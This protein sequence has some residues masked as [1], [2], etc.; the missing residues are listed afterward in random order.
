MGLHAHAHTREPLASAG[1]WRYVDEVACARGWMW[2]G[3]VLTSGC[4]EPTESPPP[5]ISSG[6][7]TSA[8]TGDDS[9]TL[10]DASATSGVADPC[11]PGSPPDGDT[12][13]E[14][15]GAFKF[16]V[17]APPG[18][19]FTPLDCA[20]AAN[21]RTNL[22]CEFF[23]VDL[24]NDPEGT[25]MS[26]PA[27]DQQFAIAV[28]N[29][30]GLSAALVEVYLPGEDD[31]FTAQLI[32]PQEAF[33]FELPS[34]SIDPTITSTT[35][36]AYRVV[37]DIPVTAYQFNPLDNTV[38]V[39]SNDASL[40]LPTHALGREYTA[41]TGDGVLLGMSA[42]DPDPINS[43]AFVSVVAVEDDTTVEI[44]PTAPLVG[45]LP[46][47]LVLDRGQVANI[48]SAHDGG[49]F[50]NL[51]GTR[52]T[53]SAPVAVFSGN[54]ATAEPIEENVCCADHLEHQMSP[55]PAWGSRYV[56]APPASPIEPDGDDEAVYRITGA[57]DGT[58]LE[59]CPSRP[60]GAPT[61]L[62]AR[63]T[64]TFQS[65]QP[66]SVRSVDPDHAF[67][68]VQFLESFQALGGERPGDPAMLVL[69]AA[70][71]FERR[72]VF[73]VPAGYVE[74]R[75]TII[76][77][78]EDGVVRLD[79]DAVDGWK[80]LAVLDGLYHRYAQVAVDEG[81]HVLESETEVGVSVFGYDEAVSFA[82]PGGAGLRVISVPP[83]EG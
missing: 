27:A 58:E 33:T 6:P 53:S 79:G 71:Q 59:Y 68:V 37:S 15:T 72:F 36:L 81:Q 76:A 67:S 80:D 42:K 30:S 35:G 12:D 73:V 23:A 29:P 69:P 64:I 26:P 43:G 57:F 66:F 9:E 3:L 51:S 32:D 16:D 55:L 28:G 38:Q 2:C 46:S 45:T 70:A 22:G 13:E 56:V 54:V 25:D 47:P 75:V 10:A 78:G 61:T 52:I 39:Y 17:G 14:T 34:Q 62:D 5:P 20:D 44:D 63:E 11:A 74:N 65:D 50:G 4:R 83:A 8:D 77:R 24:P 40:L 21:R 48:I 60:E 82:Y 41:V 7:V 19:E 31:P 18:G 1:R 49:D